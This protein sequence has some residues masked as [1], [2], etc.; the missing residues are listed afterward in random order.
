VLLLTHKPN[1][2][3]HHV[4]AVRLL[5][6]NKAIV[7]TVYRINGTM[8]QGKLA[9]SAP[10]IVQNVPI[11][12]QERP[13]NAVN[14]LGCKSLMIRKKSAGPNAPK[15]CFLIGRQGPVII[16]NKLNMAILRT[17]RACTVQGIANHAIT[18]VS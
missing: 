8:L 18:I 13:L 4:L 14:A 5:I 15:T 12:Q 9:I 11:T 3:N 16:A 17:I 6:T 2:V 7:W 1:Y 10:L